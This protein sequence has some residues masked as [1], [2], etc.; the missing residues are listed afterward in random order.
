MHP[1]PAGVCVFCGRKNLMFQRNQ[2]CTCCSWQSR[3]W[4]RTDP[5]PTC[6]VQFSRGCPNKLLPLS[7]ACGACFELIHSAG[8]RLWC[9]PQSRHGRRVASFNWPTSTWR[10]A[11]SAGPPIVGCPNGSIRNMDHGRCEKG[12]ASAA[13]YGSILIFNLRQLSGR[14]RSSVKRA[15]IE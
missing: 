15:P 14:Q 6:R 2:L 13:G 7:V 11:D 3:S 4:G 1:R 5:C 10:H 12:A 8:A 9:P